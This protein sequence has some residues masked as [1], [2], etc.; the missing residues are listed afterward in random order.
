MP[1][2]KMIPGYDDP[3]EGITMAVDGNFNFEEQLT[4]L[5]QLPDKTKKHLLAVP[6]VTFN[7]EKMLGVYNIQN[8]QIIPI[9]FFP[10]LW[11]KDLYV[12][13]SQVML[14]SLLRKKAVQYRSLSVSGHSTRTCAM[15]IDGGNILSSSLNGKVQ[16]IV[17]SDNYLKTNRIFS[18]NR[19]S[20]V[21]E[22]EYCEHL[23]RY[24]DAEIVLVGPR[25]S[26][27]N[28]IDQAN[29]L[30]HADLFTLALKDG[31]IACIDPTSFCL[32]MPSAKLAKK[33]KQSAVKSCLNYFGISSNGYS[34]DSRSVEFTGY[35]MIPETI[36]T[37]ISDNIE[38]IHKRYDRTYRKNQLNSICN[39]LE[40]IRSQLSDCGYKIVNVASC[41]DWALTHRTSL[42]GILYDGSKYIMPNFHD[43]EDNNRNEIN[44]LNHKQLTDLGFE[45]SSAFDPGSYWWSGSWDCFIARALLQKEKAFS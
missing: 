12:G 40:Q 28:F 33:M 4:L 34:S 25:D 6:Y 37:L 9:N 41:L 8:V 30:C 18:L 39:Q 16:L 14:T 22:Q 7:L 43:V 32:D 3:L 42:G 20:A 17:F 21:T 45:I 36:K 1:P 11:L 13:N 38:E 27:G 15:W 10:S 24:F 44:R 26:S 29:G 23:S 5:Q 19:F 31:V 2:I 35:R